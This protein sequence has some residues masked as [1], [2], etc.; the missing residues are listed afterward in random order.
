MTPAG[1]GPVAPVIRLGPVLYSLARA[2]RLERASPERLAEEQR[3]LLVRLLRHARAQVPRYR[4][5]ITA[6]T[7]DAFRGPEDLP[8]LP[9]L[10]RIELQTR[11]PEE[12]LATGFTTANTKAGTTSGSTGVPVTIHN[13]ERDLGYLRASYLSD[14]LS[15]GLRPWDRMAYFRVQ[16]FLR[17]PLERFG[18]LRTFHID[19]S[20]TLDEQ[21]EAFLAARPTFLVGFP[22]VIAS[23]VEEL[24]RR[25]IRYRGAH[26]VQFGGERLTPTA[27]A[28]VL[29]HLGAR[30]HEVYASVEVFTIARSCR[31][32]ALHLRSADVVVELEQEDGTAVLADGSREAEGEILVTRLRSEAM[33]LIRYRLGDRVTVGPDTCGC[34]VRTPIVLAV[35]GRSEDRLRGLDGRDFHAD[36][37][38]CVVKDFREVSRMQLIQEQPGRL[39][40][41]VVLADRADAPVTGRIEA[42]LRKAVPGFEVTVGAVDAIAP[43]RNGKVKLVKV[44][45]SA[46][47]AD[48]P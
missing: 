36:F 14:M 3:R 2:R 43:E 12:L 38:T 16:P 5:L 31:R 46:E 4:A 40:V 24:E 37:L 20:G 23:V 33:P 45:R 19:T 41:S 10:D 9:T 22:H 7:A 44:I 13:S 28:R 32:G 18:L 29:G 34:G 21:V 6:E 42:A 11:A 47:P 15:S 48:T 25:G 17:H 35:Q 39:A 8:A 30:G 27:R 1:R 26:T